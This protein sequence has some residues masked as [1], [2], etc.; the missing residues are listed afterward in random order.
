MI[1]LEA[2]RGSPGYFS[3]WG[4]RSTLSWLV[5]VVPNWGVNSM[6]RASKQR[7]SGPVGTTEA[8]DEGPVWGPGKDR[9]R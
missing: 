6:F 8:L 7:E 5:L 1:P 3:L 9:M 2:G 4:L